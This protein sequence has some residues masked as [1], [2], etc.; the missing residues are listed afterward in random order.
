[1]TQ[2]LKMLAQKILRPLLDVGKVLEEA[3][4]HFLF[5]TLFPQLSSVT[6]R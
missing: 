6:H 2:M 5:L 1:M 4:T 3:P